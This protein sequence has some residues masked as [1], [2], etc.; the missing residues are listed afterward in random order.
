MYGSK[1]DIRSDIHE[2]QQTSNLS[3]QALL[4]C[5]PV[6]WR[7]TK[8]ETNQVVVSNLRDLPLFHGKLTRRFLPTSSTSSNFIAIYW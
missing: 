3:W 4:C 7:A 8:R 1:Y 5:I 6:L 2:E